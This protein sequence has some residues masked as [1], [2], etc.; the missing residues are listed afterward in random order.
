[1]PKR[2][3]EAKEVTRRAI[4]A[5]GGTELE[6]SLTGGCHQRYTFRVPGTDKRATVV[7]SLTPSC[8]RFR[9]NTV[10]EVK[11]SILR[12]LEGPHLNRGRDGGARK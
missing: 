5:L 2:Q 11:R 10:R 8:R 4:E 9:E 3:K 1:M 7:F 12:A 6:Y